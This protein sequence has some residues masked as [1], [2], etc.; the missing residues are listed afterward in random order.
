M[1][2][3]LPAIRFIGKARDVSIRERHFIVNKIFDSQY[4]KNNTELTE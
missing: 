3:K 1:Y 2:L 4:K